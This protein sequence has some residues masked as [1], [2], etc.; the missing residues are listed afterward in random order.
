MNRKEKQSRTAQETLPRVQAES[1]KHAD[2]CAQGR[3][4]HKKKKKSNIT[5]RL[6]KRAKNT[7]GY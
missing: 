7:W 6:S 2:V 3:E 5:N 4:V 1:Q